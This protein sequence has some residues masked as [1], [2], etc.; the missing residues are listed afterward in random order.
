MTFPASPRLLVVANPA[1]GGEGRRRGYLDALVARGCSVRVV[2]TTAP[3]EAEG[4]AR[5][6]D[7]GAFDAI[8]AA[9]GDGTVHEIVNGLARGPGAGRTHA[10]LPLGLIPLGTA[11]VLAAEIGLTTAPGTVAEVIARGRRR[12]VR[13]GRFDDRFDSGRFLLMAGAGFDADVVAGVDPAFKRG[14]G[15]FAYAWRTMTGAFTYPFPP[16][17]V[18]LDGAARPA[19]GA[20]VCRGRHYG[21]GHIAAPEARLDAPTVQVCLLTRP[22]ALNVFRYAGA[23]LAG[24]LGRLA[25]VEIVTA[26]TVRLDGPAGLP[27]QIDGDIRAR[28]PVTIDA[29]P[30]TIELIVPDPA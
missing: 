16:L 7:A 18:T 21:G 17:T 30:E 15:K 3:G 11:N 22:G 27:V 28:L 24:T 14:A 4:I 20:V 10:P 29:A 6:A 23:L 5:A 13:L 8:I 9:G 1:S 19:F 26:T 12:T 2:E 25:D